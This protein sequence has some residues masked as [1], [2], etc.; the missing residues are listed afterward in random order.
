MK[1]HACGNKDNLM[2]MQL[3]EKEV[4]WLCPH[5]YQIHLNGGK[6]FIPSFIKA[7]KL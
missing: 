2:K 4:R 1:C 3:T 5:H 7:S 6:E